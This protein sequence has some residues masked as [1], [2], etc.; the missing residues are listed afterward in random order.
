MAYFGLLWIGQEVGSIRSL[1]R[2]LQSGESYSEEVG[3]RSPNGGDCEKGAGS[4]MIFE[5]D[6][7]NP[8]GIN[9]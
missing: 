8:K 7:H 1:L 9:A 3:M 5:L 2:G 4:S 6:F